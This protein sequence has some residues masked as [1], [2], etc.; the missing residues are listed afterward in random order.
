[1]EAKHDGAGPVRPDSPSAP[2][3]LIVHNGRQKG[4]RRPLHQPLTMIGRAPGCDLRLNVEGVGPLHCG[5][6]NGHDGLHLRDFHGNG[7]TLVNGHA[8][9]GAP[10]RHGDI[11]TVGPF[12]F[13]IC[14]N[15]PTPAQRVA[16]AQA[17]HSQERDALRIQAAA[18]AA[19]QAALGEEE[20]RLEQRRAALQQQEEQLAAHLDEKRKR[21]LELRDQ[22]RAAHETLKKERAEHEEKVRKDSK[23]IENGRR[24]LAEG[25]KKLASDREDL[26][27][28]HGKLKRRWERQT[29]EQSNAIRRRED[30]I[31]AEKRRLESDR[32][33]LH[34]ERQSL[35]Q[36]KLRFNGDSELG[37]RQLKAEWDALRQEQTEQEERRQQ[38]TEEHRR[39]TRQLDE[40]QNLLALAEQEMEDQKQQMQE[41]RLHLEKEAQGLENRIHNY[42]RKIT[43]ME[44][45]VVRL[46]QQARA[47]RAANEPSAATPVSS[48]PGEPPS[49][50]D[51]TTTVATAPSPSSSA[52]EPAAAAP[53]RPEI[54]LPAVETHPADPRVEEKLAHLEKLSG[55][56]ADQRLHL[57]EQCQRMVQGQHNWQQ[58]RDAAAADLEE[59]GKRLHSRELELQQREQGLEA[60]ECRQRQMHE[61]ADA[62]RRQLEAW[63]SRLSTREAMW[64][65]DRDR[66]L[67]S[68][69]NREKLAEAKLTAIMQVHQ[70]WMRRRRREIQWLQAERTAFAKLRQEC[71]ALR[72]DFLRRGGI[73]ERE[74]RALAEQALAM[75]E[76]QQELIARS[77]QPAGAARRLEKLRKRWTALSAASTKTLTVQRQ[78]LEK[79]AA[80]LQAYHARLKQQADKIAAQEAELARQVTTWERSQMQANI[81]MGRMRTDL[82]ISQSQRD[83]YEQQVHSLHDEV[84]RVARLLMDETEAASESQHNAA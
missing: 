37:R 26:S 20:A 3:E 83:R 27:K 5:L 13:Q 4:A 24:E 12:Q 36:E 17:R 8:S 77:E 1:M 81:E 79:E 28:L 15:G 70:R 16:E 49:P 71:A 58:E 21:L 73:L 68:V 31:A 6:V 22:A 14:Y 45:E 33:K 76:F 50:T 35:Y 7:G 19:Q 48:V 44:R 9:T 46:Q 65:S 2:V 59:M 10:L 47:A 82:H 54:T 55:E 30:E 75:E 41:M 69:Q 57:L 34:R 61:E 63:Q 18:V 25:T 78:A 60:A 53:S 43:D 32:E 42:R 52:P 40:R 23:E 62:L 56:L 39:R 64:E 84:E 51:G 11:V 29:A 38:H 80:E 66:L 74:Q 67:V 72:Q